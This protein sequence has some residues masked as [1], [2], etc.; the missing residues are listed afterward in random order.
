MVI[1][2]GEAGLV[3]VGSFGYCGAIVFMSLLREW[4]LEGR[5]AF[6]CMLSI[7]TI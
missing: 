2:Y 5:F 1:N 6:T 3:M 7:H 4:L